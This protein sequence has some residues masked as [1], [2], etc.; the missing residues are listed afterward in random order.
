M[1]SRRVSRTRRASC[2]RV[3]NGRCF[4]R[5]RG[6]RDGADRVHGE[7]EVRVRGGGDEAVAQSL[8]FHGAA[9]LDAARRDRVR[10]RG[11]ASLA[12]QERQRGAKDF[13]MRWI[14][15]DREFAAQGFVH[16]PQHVTPAI[17][18]EMDE[19]VRGEHAP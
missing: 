15:V 4:R 2:R 8:F 10:V 5:L 11:L 12:P 9:E 6:D 17:E 7:V 19:R 3:R 13:V 1:G 14:R 18:R 16:D